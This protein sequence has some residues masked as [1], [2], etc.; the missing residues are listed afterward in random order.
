MRHNSRRLYRSRN[1]IIWGVCQGFSDWSGIS[2]GVVRTVAVVSFI[3]SGFF[4]V[5]FLYAGAALILPVEP[6]TQTHNH[7][8][9][10]SER[11]WERRFYGR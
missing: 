8:Y 1:G 7:Y 5:A 3:L 10:S 9:G 2:V 11:D 6:V 4:P